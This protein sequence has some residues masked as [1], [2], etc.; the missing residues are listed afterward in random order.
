MVKK[1]V[2]HFNQN[3]P[4]HGIYKILWMKTNF[5]LYMLIQGSVAKINQNK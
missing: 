2:N 3:I 1:I 4:F 5:F